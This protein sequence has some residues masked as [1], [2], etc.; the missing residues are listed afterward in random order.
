M[1]GESDP[2]LSPQETEALLEAMRAGSLPAAGDAQAPQGPVDAADL[3]DPERILRRAQP[4][5]DRR[6]PSLVVPLRR[7]FMRHAE[8][9]V[10]VTEMPSELQPWSVVVDALEEGTA[11]VRVRTTTGGEGLL[12][13]AAPLAAFVVER[14]LG[15]PLVEPAPGE[16]PGASSSIEP[17]GGFSQI[18][19]RVLRP[20]A[21]DMLLE[22][23][24]A[25][26]A[27]H[28]SLLFDGFVE[29]PG[30]LPA[31]GRYEPVLRIPVRLAPT[32]MAHEELALSLSAA[33]VLGLEPPAPKRPAS[34]PRR[35]PAGVRSR[36]RTVLM[37]AEVEVAAVL[38]SIP[39][40]VEQLL[41]WRAGDVLRLD[42]V[43]GDAVP[44]TVEGEEVGRGEP[45]VR[46][47]NLAV[48]LT[49]CPNHVSAAGSRGPVGKPSEENDERV[50][51]A[52]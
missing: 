12:T 28:G 16:E 5:V 11:V 26:E 21:R 38:G 52:E 14:R 45:T 7:A 27:G 22:L 20:F 1:T 50:A 39:T 36:L 24:R 2:L 40:T 17:G 9:G 44:L 6:L 29:H 49:A 48:R 41:S 42:T 31:L 34:P 43:A 25:F 3:S 33:A 8:S 18:D 51:A 23:G 35:Q 19:R 37:E 4:R 47:G 13:V 15:A 46:A 10:E 30:E 32:G